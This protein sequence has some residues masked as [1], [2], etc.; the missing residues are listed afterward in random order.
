MEAK[1][2]AGWTTGNNGGVTPEQIEMW[3]AKHRRI[4]AVEVVDGNEAHTGYF[5]RPD[6]E[7]ISAVRKLGKTDEIKGAN[8]LFDNSWLGGSTL[9]REDAVL[10]LAA[11]GQLDSLT[12]K[13]TSAIKNL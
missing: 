13:V 11:I 5:R 3:K 4:Y 7:T 10:K 8:A 2:K 9:L 6:M 1:E 12:E